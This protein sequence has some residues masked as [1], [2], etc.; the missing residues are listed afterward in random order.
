[1]RL[2]LICC[3]LAVLSLGPR[4]A[5]STL[6]DHHQHFFS[7][8]VTAFAPTLPVV[9]ADDLI[10]LLDA[11]GIRRAVI[12]SQGY[13]FGNPNRPPV[14][15]EYSKVKVENDWTSQQIA[16]YPGR[17]RGFCGL[18]P[19]KDYAVNEVTRCAKDPH[20]KYGVKM[21]F[22]N[23]DVD[24]LNAEHVEQLRR[25]FRTANDHR[26]AIVVHLRTSVTRKRPYGAQHARAFIDNVAS[27][28]PDAPIQI[29]HLAGAGG[30]DDP[31]VDEALGVF[32][33][34][35]ARRDPRLSRFYFDVSGVAG[36]G[37]WKERV[38][39]IVTRIR[40]LGVE[41]V[42]YGSDGAVGENSPQKALAAFRQLPL[43][44]DE[45]RT[46]ENNV[47]PYMR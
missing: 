13:Q 9:T 7:K 38:D 43:T 16:R 24:V 8:T 46:I 1:M 29:A 33:E 15:D 5:P 17:L 27:E 28:T 45:F 44:P 22:G 19:L 32:A 2:R 18:N 41:R 20:L 47:A 26:M 10:P 35:A 3:V 42:L 14:E 21:H 4:Q 39:M 40:Q 23:S 12:F 6:I 25:V 37:N 31:L 11:A 34:A 36:L 30:Y